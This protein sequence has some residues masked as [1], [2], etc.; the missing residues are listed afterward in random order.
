MDQHVVTHAPGA[1]SQ[2]FAAPT[3]CLHTCLGLP[4][5]TSSLDSSELAESR[6]AKDA[7]QVPH[8][9]GSEQGTWCWCFTPVARFKKRLTQHSLVD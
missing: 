8:F 4:F 1:E 2:V 7:L 6:W 9:M 5:K 3:A